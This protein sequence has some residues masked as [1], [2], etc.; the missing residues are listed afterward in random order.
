[1]AL[2]GCLRLFVRIRSSPEISFERPRGP[3]L[4]R[5]SSCPFAISFSFHPY[6]AFYTPIRLAHSFHNSHLIPHRSVACVSDTKRV[7]CMFGSVMPATDTA[8][9]K[10]RWVITR[11]AYLVACYGVPLSLLDIVIRST[12]R[13]LGHNYTTCSQR[14]VRCHR[15][16]SLQIS[17]ERHYNCI[18][19]PAGM[20]FTSPTCN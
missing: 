2:E 18:W 7:S 8:L 13:S 1:M 19:L 14:K 12:R 4:R 16:W 9:A 20:V 10:Y 11:I 17:H 5:K 3:N 6:P 15:F